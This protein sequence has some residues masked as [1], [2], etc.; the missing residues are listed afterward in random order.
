[1][2]EGFGRRNVPIILSA[3][4]LL[5]S[6]ENQVAT[7]AAIGYD[8]LFLEDKESPRIVQILCARSA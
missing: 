6:V 8:Q 2:F 1:M 5:P 7:V 3:C 4:E